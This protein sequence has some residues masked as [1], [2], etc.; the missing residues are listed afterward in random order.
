MLADGE[1]HGLAVLRRPFIGRWLRVLV[2]DE[3]AQAADPTE[4]RDANAGVRRDR[5]AVGAD[6]AEAG[7]APR[8]GR[9]RQWG[10]VVIPELCLAAGLQAEIVRQRHGQRRR[11]NA[12][13]RCAE[14]QLEERA[15]TPRR[16]RYGQSVQRDTLDRDPGLEDP[17]PAGNRD[18]R[19]QREGHAGETRIGDHLIGCRVGD[20]NEPLRRRRR[21]QPGRWQDGDLFRRHGDVGGVDRQPGARSVGVDT[22]HL[23][24][25]RRR[26]QD[27]IARGVG[28]GLCGA[29]RQTDA[30]QGLAG[31]QDEA[32][33]DGRLARCA[34]CQHERCDL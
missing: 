27:E 15:R 14:E 5:L 19:G 26:Q 9:A 34:Y 23:P 10:G 25:R 33:G 12:A 24:A 4:S 1:V 30:L 20:G 13:H 32:A 18:A 31:G 17:V 16:R 11:W 7:Q 22:E 21:R 29:N 2:L 3:T 28:G 8:R 6:R